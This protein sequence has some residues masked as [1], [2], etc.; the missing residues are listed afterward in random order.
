MD[1]IRKLL[2]QWGWGRAGSE[3]S[4]SSQM[5]TGDIWLVQRIPLYPELHNLALLLKIVFLKLENLEASFS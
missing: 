3:S 4:R 5:I 1:I 2:F